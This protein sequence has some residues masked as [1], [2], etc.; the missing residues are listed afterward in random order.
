MMEL[1]QI[2]SKPLKEMKGNHLCPGD[3]VVN[4]RIDYKLTPGYRYEVS[5]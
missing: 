2:D 5:L 3:I 4:F 1:N